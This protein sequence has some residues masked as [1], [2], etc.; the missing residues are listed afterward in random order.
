MALRMAR[1][2]ISVAYEVACRIA[3]NTKALKGPL[4]AASRVG[5]KNQAF[6]LLNSLVDNRI[7]IYLIECL[8]IGIQNRKIIS[9][10]PS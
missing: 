10:L 5:S 6:C 8:G 2:K 4:S 9:G 1:V 3:I 7:K